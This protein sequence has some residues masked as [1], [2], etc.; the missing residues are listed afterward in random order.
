MFSHIEIQ[1]VSTCTAIPKRQQIRQWISSALATSSI[2]TPNAAI[3]IRIVDKPESAELN[4][5]YRK[6]TGPTNVLSFPFDSSNIIDDNNLLG[7]LVICAPLLIEEAQTQNKTIEAHWAHLIIHGTLH[8]LGYD[9]QNDEEATV[10]ETKEIT[11][12][13]QLGYTNP[14]LDI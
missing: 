7:D 1:N 11:I 4:K 5:L 9:H 6:K 14:Y 10:M 13:A 8:L 3:T 12:L 2:D